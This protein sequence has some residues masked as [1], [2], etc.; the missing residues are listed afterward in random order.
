MEMSTITVEELYNKHHTH[1]VNILKKRGE[2]HHSALDLVQEL[3]VTLLRKEK[4]GTL[5]IDTNPLSYLCTA[6][7]NQRKMMIRSKV[8]KWEVLSFDGLEN[9]W[10]HPSCPTTPERECMAR[11]SL[12]WVKEALELLPKCYQDEKYT[13][14]LQH[15]GYVASRYKSNFVRAKKYFLFNLTGEIPNGYGIKLHNT[16]IKLR[17]PKAKKAMEHY[18]RTRD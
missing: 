2:P 16:A 18:R 15:I 11:R 17:H 1:L 7:I 4:E 8:C 9:D 14:P 12:E 5:Q 3:F 6:A 10:W 13:N